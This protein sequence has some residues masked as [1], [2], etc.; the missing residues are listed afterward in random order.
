MGLVTRPASSSPS[1]E[2]NRPLFHPHNNLPHPA[3]LIPDHNNSHFTP[4]NTYF[5]HLHQLSL[6][7]EAAAAAA[8]GVSPGRRVAPMA[9]TPRRQEWS[10]PSCYVSS[11][12][13]L[14]SDDSHNRRDH[15]DEGDE[16]FE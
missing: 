7:R 6:L 16:E 10:P 4:F 2:E 3:A 5:P 12:T 11:S 15:E 9:S 1:V 8:V 14:E 13:T